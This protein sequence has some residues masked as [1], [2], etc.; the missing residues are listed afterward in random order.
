MGNEVVHTTNMIL[1]L[2]IAFYAIILP[3]LMAFL[4]WTVGKD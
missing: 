4:Y 2:L 1:S 3:G